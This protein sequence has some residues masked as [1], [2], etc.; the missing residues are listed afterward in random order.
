M[1][2]MR[3]FI[4][5][6]KKRIPLFLFFIGFS[7][8]LYAQ[9]IKVKD[10]PHIDKLPINVINTI[11]QDSEGYMWYGTEDGLCRDDGYNI[12]TFRSDFKNPDILE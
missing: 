11:F 4:A 9:K 3:Y 2:I 10:I 1:L 8:C 7:F 6:A 5:N 12:H